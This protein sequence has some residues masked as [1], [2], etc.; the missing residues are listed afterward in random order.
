MTKIKPGIYTKTIQGTLQNDLK[1]KYKY[2]CYF[3]HV[4]KFHCRS[5]NDFVNEK[6]TSIATLKDFVP[7]MIIICLLLENTFGQGTT[8]SDRS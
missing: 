6:K 7:K 3:Q 8:V 1:D 2:F 4:R 5:K